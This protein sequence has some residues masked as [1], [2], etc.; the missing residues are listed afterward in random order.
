MNFTYNGV[1]VEIPDSF[2][3]HHAGTTIT[4]RIQSGSYE[5]DEYKMLRD[6]VTEDSII[7]ELGGS[8]GVLAC[9]TGKLMPDSKK[10]VVVEAHPNLVPVLEANRDRNNLEFNIHE[11][12]AHYNNNEVSFKYNEYPL[13]GQIFH[14]GGFG[15]TGTVTLNGTTPMD[16]EEKYDL[17]FNVLNCDIEGSEY[18]LLDNL[19]D[20]FKNFNHLIVEFHTWGMYPGVNREMLE[21]K[22]SQFFNVSRSHSVTKFSKR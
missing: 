15:N 12:A 7:L 3:K 9:L 13:N 10:L 2:L 6:I 1:E 19:F 20:Y 21:K 17:K 16:L 4:G 5:A 22:Y 8:V 11:G 14:Q 18:M